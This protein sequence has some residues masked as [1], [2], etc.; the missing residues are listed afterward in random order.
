MAQPAAS[1]STCNSPPSTAV[2]RSPSGVEAIGVAWLLTRDARYASRVA[3][4]MERV[5]GFASWNPV[6]FLD[7]AEMTMAVALA[8][9]WCHDAFTPA[10][11]PLPAPPS[12]RAHACPKVLPS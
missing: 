8:H 10:R 12:I 4:E 11:F 7:V 5:C 2:S 9:D 6:H 1:R 3:L